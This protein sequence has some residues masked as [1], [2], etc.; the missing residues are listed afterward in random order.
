MLFQSDM[1]SGRI[2]RIWVA[3]AFLLLGWVSGAIAAD[4]PDYPEIEYGYPD[5][6][7]F[8][9]SVNAMN[10]PDSPMLRYARVLM[11]K[12]GLSWRARQ[13]PARRLFRNL[14]SGET[15][16]SILV[17][18]SSLLDYCIFSRQPVYSTT[19]RVYFI[20]DKPPVLRREDLAG[21]NI[22]TIRG[23]SYAGLLKYITDP[24]NKVEHLAAPTH[25]AAFQMLAHGRGDYVLDYESAAG[26]ILAADPIEGL[27]SRPIGTLDIYLVL[28][29]AYPR[30]GELMERLEEIAGTLDINRILK[31]KD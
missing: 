5:Q 19:L 18:A 21:K 8:V 23:Y 7:I 4:T 29:R 14:Q 3:L 2:C 24:V 22:I 11:E 13:Y 1:T 30:A 6:S 15:V 10:Q 26:D 28:S 25:K 17:K 9:A 27:D 20:G 31:G 16:F 12:A